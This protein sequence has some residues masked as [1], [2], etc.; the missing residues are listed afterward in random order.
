MPDT[1]LSWHGWNGFRASKWQRHNGTDPNWA[2][3]STSFESSQPKK[4]ATKTKNFQQFLKRLRTEALFL[5]LRCIPV[6]TG[7]LRE[8]GALGGGGN[9]SPTQ[10]R[11]KERSRR[12]TKCSEARRS[13]ILVRISW[14]TL[15]DRRRKEMDQGEYW[16]S[17]FSEVLNQEMG[18]VCRGYGV[19]RRDRRCS[20]FVLWSGSS[21][22]LTWILGHKSYVF[23]D[24]LNPEAVDNLFFN[25]LG[26]W[27]SAPLRELLPLASEFRPLFGSP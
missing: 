20:K 17:Y 26:L 21:H 6:T 7:K 23:W 13:R 9:G 8:G 19:S 16:E 22:F 15:A 18:D 10:L 25:I 4:E 3:S 2:L 11:W 1:R 24:Q 5:K 27:L 14:R 12:M